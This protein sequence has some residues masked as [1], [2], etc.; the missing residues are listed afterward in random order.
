M[1]KAHQIE[2]L[3]TFNL[4]EHIQRKK[5][6]RI[7]NNCARAKTDN[8]K[9]D[10]NKLRWTGRQKGRNVERQIGRNVERQDEIKKRS[11]IAVQNA[12]GEQHTEPLM[13]QYP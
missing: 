6:H 1:R 5:L 7:A 2:L 9:T 12:S 4:N 8:G 3:T 10:R 11:P 13:S